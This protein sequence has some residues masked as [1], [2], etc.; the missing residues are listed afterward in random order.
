MINNLY[1]P[2]K[3]GYSIYFPKPL[4]LYIRD[5]YVYDQQVCG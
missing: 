3:L 1:N 4:S 5:Q 2:K